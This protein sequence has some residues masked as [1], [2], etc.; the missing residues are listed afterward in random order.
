M[1]DEVER[2]ME[3]LRKAEHARREAINDLVALAAVGNRGLVG[4][5]GERFAADYYGVKLPEKSPP[6]YDVVA[7][8]DRLIQVR[9]L[10]STPDNYRASMGP[11]KEPYHYLLAI[12]L[13]EDF[14]IERAMEVPRAALERHYPHGKR[15]SWTQ[16]LWNDPDTK[17][18]TAEDLATK[19]AGA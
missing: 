15:V 3:R 9:T 11:M 17:Q 6:G 8:G 10:R 14:S 5:L 1:P 13:N 19:G 18:I 16:K 2:A 12:R 4:S 7:P